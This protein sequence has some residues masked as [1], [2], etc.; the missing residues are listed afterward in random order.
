MFGELTG[1]LLDENHTIRHKV[2]RVTNIAENKKSK[3]EDYFKDGE[4]LIPLTNEQRYY[5]G[6]A[7]IS[8]KW[9]KVPSNHPMKDMMAQPI[10]FRQYHIVTKNPNLTPEDLEDIPMYPMSMAQDNEILW[11]TYPIVGHKT[12]VQK[13]IDLGFSCHK[14]TGEVFWGFT[15][16]TV[17]PEIFQDLF[18]EM[19]SYCVQERRSFST[20]LQICVYEN[21]PSHIER[22][23]EMRKRVLEELGMPLDSTLDDFA[24]RFGGPTREDYIR[25][26]YR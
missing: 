24:E 6:L 5:Y 25:W 1:D 11:G 15:S 20:G 4:Y 10:M 16:F 8:S 23:L 14:K 18:Q 3:A 13:D 17:N 9:E 2:K 22:E 21:V 12:L 7:P 26:V 19:A